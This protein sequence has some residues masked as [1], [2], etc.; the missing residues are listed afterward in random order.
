MLA[1]RWHYLF[2]LLILLPI[3]N[4]NS[5]LL[6][7]KSFRIIFMVVPFLSGLFSIPVVYCIV[8]RVNVSHNTY[9]SISV[10]CQ[11]FGISFVCLS[12]LIVLSDCLVVLRLR[13]N[14]LTQFLLVFAHFNLIPSPSD[15]CRWFV[16]TDIVIDRFEN[17]WKDE[18]VILEVTAKFCTF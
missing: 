11:A 13:P 10:L 6:E 15:L 17:D 18:T 7:E 1:L 14:A 9:F 3:N 2:T 4:I 16:K 8:T 5:F 12:C